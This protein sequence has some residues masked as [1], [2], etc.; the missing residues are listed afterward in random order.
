V[1]VADANILSN[2]TNTVKRNTEVLLQAGREVG[3]EVNTEKTKYIV[4]SCHQNTGQNKNLLIA[5]KSL[6]NA[7]KLKYLGTRIASQNCVHKE[8]KR[9]PATVLFRVFPSH[10]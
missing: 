3:L 8:I 4:V 2:N 10:L 7:S 6:E 9:M 5:N 1:C